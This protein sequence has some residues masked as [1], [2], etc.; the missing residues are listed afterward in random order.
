MKERATQTAPL[1]I[2]GLRLRYQAT[3]KVGLIIAADTLLLEIGSYAGTFLDSYGLIEW[4]FAKLFSFGGGLNFLN[5]E[6]D[7]D[8]DI[9]AELRNSYNGVTAFF[10]VHF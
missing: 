3:D 2:F 9:I 5:L 6:L 8:D 10:G 4:R 1:P 7:Y